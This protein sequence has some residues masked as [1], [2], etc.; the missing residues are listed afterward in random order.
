MLEYLFGSK[1]RFKLL[2]IF[3]REPIERYFVRQLG[4]LTET[5]INAVRREL[6]L[7]LRSGIISEVELVESER[8]S[9]NASAGGSLRKYYTLNV[10]STIYPELRDLLLKD[11]LIGERQFVAEL[12]E[13]GGEIDLIVL[14]GRFTG[15]KT[16]KTDILLVGAV[17]EGVVE[18]I[19]SQAE[20]DLGFEVRYTIFSKEEF[21]DRRRMMDK[22][23]YSIFEA[24]HLIIEDKFKLLSP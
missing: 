6:D 18:K 9:K 5:Q 20:K 16:A 13:K 24:D 11:Q 12:K 1:T 10:G 23:L 7:L 21:S 3:F 4:R 19:V 8:R 17:R 14:S 22:F 2:K 15:D